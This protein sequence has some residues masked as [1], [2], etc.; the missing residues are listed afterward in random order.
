[1]GI[2]SSKYIFTFHKEGCKKALSGRDVFWS[3][4]NH[5]AEVF[6]GKN[7]LCRMM[8]TLDSIYL[9]NLKFYDTDKLRLSKFNA[10]NLEFSNYAKFCLSLIPI[11]EKVCRKKLRKF[12]RSSKKGFIE[13][14]KCNF[15]GYMM[16]GMAHCEKFYR[17]YSN[18]NNQLYDCMVG[19]S[20]FNKNYGVYVGDIPELYNIIV[21]LKVYED[22]NLLCD[23]CSI[24]HPDF[25]AC[26]YYGSNSLYPM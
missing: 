8:G 23:R 14:I 24:K 2:N 4:I 25:E 5:Y 12:M 18:E 22:N 9:M 13:K 6:F 15:D 16:D 1:M 26:V 10:F 20:I 17:I 3:I 11:I 19:T 7:N 21:P